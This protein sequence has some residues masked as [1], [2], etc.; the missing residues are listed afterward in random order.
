MLQLLS[1]MLGV[2]AVGDECGSHKRRRLM[3]ACFGGKTTIERSLMSAGRSQYSSSVRDT[4]AASRRTETCVPRPRQTVVHSLP[5]HHQRS[6]TARRQQ[7]RDASEESETT[8]TGCHGDCDSA[9]TSDERH[10][11]HAA[12]Q[13]TDSGYEATCC[14]H[15]S[16]LALSTGAS[17]SANFSIWPN[18]KCP[19]FEF[20]RKS[21]F[22][23]FCLLMITRGG[24]V[25]VIISVIGSN[26]T[27][28]TVLLLITQSV[29]YRV[30]SSRPL[31]RL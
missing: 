13:T 17:C 9:M 2:D 31:C 1:V 21:K 19:V 23:H 10:R 22:I 24:P 3:P 18:F 16:R 29:H 7:V 25:R 11:H 15:T 12:G 26:T 4:A 8:V 27:Q 28:R 30:N 20:D 6:S 14:E 5:A